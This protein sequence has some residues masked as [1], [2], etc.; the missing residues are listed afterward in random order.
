[1]NNVCTQTSSEYIIIMQLKMWLGFALVA[2]LLEVVTPIILLSS[3]AAAT[4]ATAVT[5]GLTVSNP[6]LAAVGAGAVLLGAAGLAGGLI[7]GLAGGRRRGRRAIV[8]VADDGFSVDAIDIL[9]STAGALDRETNC[10]LLLVC[11]LAATPENQLAADEAL[12]M[13]LFG[14][15]RPLS[16]DMINGPSTPFQLAAFLGRQSQSASACAN[17]YS[18]C[19]Y[20]SNQIMEII[21]QNGNAI[22]Q[23]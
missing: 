8:G 22:G 10:G 12:L 5:L 17:T 3:T 1:E 7:G 21:R 6:A 18:K 16:H 23:V 11:E 14:D 20:N 2:A 13:T 15:A 4:T 9:F 19:Q